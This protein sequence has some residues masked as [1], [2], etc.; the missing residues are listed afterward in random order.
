M[1]LMQLVDGPAGVAVT[2]D[3]DQKAA[4]PGSARKKKAG[5][6]GGEEGTGGC[7]P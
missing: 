6:E 4:K 2:A 5:E 3:A 7:R 1:A